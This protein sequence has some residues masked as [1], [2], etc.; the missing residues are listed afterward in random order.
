MRRVRDCGGAERGKGDSMKKLYLV[1]AVAAMTLFTGCE[2]RALPP[3]AE[4]QPPAISDSSPGGNAVVVDEVVPAEEA[5]EKSLQEIIDDYASTA[6]D[7]SPGKR[8]LLFQIEGNFTGS[9]NREIIGFYQ[10]QEYRYSK[11][12]IH[13]VFCFVCNESGEK[14]ESVYPIEYL[15]AEINETKGK[16]TGLSDALGRAIIWKDWKIGYVSDFN[17]NE[18][19]E[20]YLYRR[21][22]MGE[23]P[24]FFEFDGTAFVRILEIISTS[25][26]ITGIDPEKKAVTIE[27]NFRP[28]D[29]K[30]IWE[31]R[32]Y[33]WDN[34]TGQYEKIYSEP[35]EQWP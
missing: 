25:I 21:S 32:V 19:E 26:A 20:L 4:D 14:I 11:S 28:G 29:G 6:P 5:K 10:I 12:S 30:G 22:G 18:K 35:I 9:G 33:A 31:K 23:G 16:E 2:K 17:G 13:N 15:T 1:W 34:D 27:A 8:L 3:A 7:I 24:L